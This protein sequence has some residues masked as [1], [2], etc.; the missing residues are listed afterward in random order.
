MDI[1]KDVSVDWIKALIW[2]SAIA[3]G[4][5]L[6]F[7]RPRRL[8]LAALGSVIVLMVA[9]SGAGIYVFNHVGDSRWDSK[10][11]DRINPPM[12][13]ETPVIG[14]YLESLDGLM[15]GVADRVN[16][17]ADFRAAL[18]VALEFF[19][20]AGWALVICIPF[21][22]LSLIIAY[23]EAKRRTAELLKH[24]TQLAELARELQVIKD[25]LGFPDLDKD[26]YRPPANPT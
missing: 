21:A 24:K 15:H 10:A 2:I 19:V 12:L 17:F 6:G 5:L 11:E 25:R 4:L 14:Q 9:S 13:A 8:H 20:A 7:W 1:L 26:D 18:P 16:E 3:T 23:A 22:L